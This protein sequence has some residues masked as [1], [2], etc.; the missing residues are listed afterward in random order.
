M[1]VKDA[2]D[3]WEPD[4][5]VGMFLQTSMF[6]KTSDKLE[7]PPEPFLANQRSEKGTCNLIHSS[8][9]QRSEE[10]KWSHHLRH[11]SKPK[12]QRTE[13]GAIT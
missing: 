13:I 11:S 4:P 10:G 12:G 2:L 3:S 5:F 6:F 7:L 8:R 9:K 1:M